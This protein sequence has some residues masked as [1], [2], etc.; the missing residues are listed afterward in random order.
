MENLR[1]AFVML[2]AAISMDALA[3]TEAEAGKP[4]DADKGK[5]PAEAKPPKDS[6]DNDKGEQS[7]RKR[8]RPLP[9]PDRGDSFGDPDLG[10]PAGTLY[11]VIGGDDVK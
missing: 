4:A 2:S 8:V 7:R 10:M 11:D 5:P 3:T 1:K 6:K 9:R